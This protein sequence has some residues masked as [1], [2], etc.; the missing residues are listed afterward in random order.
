MRLILNFQN[1]EEF[2]YKK[3]D[4]IISHIKINNAECKVIYIDNFDIINSDSKNDFNK[5]VNSLDKKSDEYHLLYS[6]LPTFYSNS[7]RFL[8]KWINAVDYVL[9][10]YNFD[11]IIINK[12][13]SV[14][15]YIPYYESEGESNKSLFYKNYDF[16]PSHLFNYLIGNGF[17]SKIILNEQNKIPLLLRIFVRRYILILIKFFV[18]LFKIIKSKKKILNKIYRNIYFTRSVVHTNFIKPLINKKNSIIISSDSYF[19]KISNINYSKKIFKNTSYSI[20]NFLK[21]NDLLNALIICFKRIYKFYKVKFIMIDG[22]KININDLLIESSIYQF[23]VDIN[24]FSINRLLQNISINDNSK[25]INI[26]C[27]EM[28]TQYP[29]WLNLSFKKNKK[30]KTYQ[31]QTAA[32]DS[33]NIPNFIFCDR[34]IFSSNKEKKFF[35]NQFQNNKSKLIFKGNAIFENK[36]KVSNYLK[37]IIIFSQTHDY[38]DQWKLIHYLI[39]LSN[40][41]SIKLYLKPHPR[42]SKKNLLKYKSYNINLIKTDLNILDQIDN[43]DLAITRV[44]SITQDLILKGIPVINFLISNFDK[45]CNYLPYINKSYITNVDRFNDLDNIIYNYDEFK[46]KFQKFRIKYLKQQGID[47]GVNSLYKYING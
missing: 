15:N 20:Y 45:N 31:L 1:N 14:D 38:D 30:V 35:Q 3:N 32:L 21:F 18:Q 29:Y 39:N 5:Y 8:K 4:I 23:D 6:S 47:K 12:F 26:Y 9:N 44:S 10:E 25:N 27:C 22:V 33:I 42:E 40:E 7:F 16:I 28:I 34:F 11:K 43:F 2:N 41:K 17:K 46:F 24:T 37:K 36:I 13:Y 19:S